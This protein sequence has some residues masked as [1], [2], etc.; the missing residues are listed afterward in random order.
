MSC[1]RGKRTRSV[2]LHFI[3]TVLTSYL[4]G[5]SF[6]HCESAVVS[7]QTFTFFSALNFTCDSRHVVPKLYPVAAF[8]DPGIDRTTSCR[9]RGARGRAPKA[10]AHLLDA[11]DQ[12]GLRDAGMQPNP[13]SDP[14]VSSHLNT[15][16]PRI[17]RLWIR[18]R[19]GV[20]S[21]LARHQPRRP[22]QKRGLEA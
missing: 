7:I 13:A 9:E 3:V 16:F 8:V 12:L 15:R 19:L 1:S 6:T 5:L 2:C 11:R 14:E 22:R 21:I 4:L 18:Q 17:R 10:P 20:V